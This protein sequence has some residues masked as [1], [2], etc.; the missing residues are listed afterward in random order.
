MRSEEHSRRKVAAA[1][2]FVISAK[3]AA[4]PISRRGA[5]GPDPSKQAIVESNEPDTG[6]KEAKS[7]KRWKKAEAVVTATVEKETETPKEQPKRS[8]RQQV[9]KFKVAASTKENIPTKQPFEEEEPQQLPAKSSAPK[10]KRKKIKPV[11]SPQDSPADEVIPVNFK[12]PE[13][14]PIEQAKSE[15]PRP[16]KSKKRATRGPRSTKSKAKLKEKTSTDEAETEVESIVGKQPLDRVEQ[17]TIRTEDD[18]RTIGGQSPIVV[19]ETGTLEIQPSEQQE[20][21]QPFSPDDSST[22]RPPSI[23]SMMSTRA[24]AVATPQNETSI[25]TILE[26]EDLNTFEEFFPELAVPRPLMESRRIEIPS[27]TAEARA[28]TVEEWIRSEMQK[29]FEALRLDGEKAIRR[30]QNQAQ[31]IRQQISSL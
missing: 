27:L 28:M 26:E 30:F 20:H 4:V 6:Q 3:A 15:R 24:P 5:K 19:L 22:P 18:T 9:S 2:A 14:P 7:K 8:T 10:S 23:R 21:E 25:R 12:P 29:Q 13:E 11:P 31:D 1:C 17:T 16:S